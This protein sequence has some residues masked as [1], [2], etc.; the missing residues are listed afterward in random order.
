MKDV[1]HEYLDDFMV[2]HIDDILIFSKNMEDHECHIHLVLEKFA[3]VGFYTK[4]E[5][6]EF[7]QFEVELLGY[8]IFGSTFAWTLR[9][10]RQLLIRLLQLLFKMFNVF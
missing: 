10:F 7:H 4:L 9:R 8:V 5:K 2:C 3:E 6:C 1:F